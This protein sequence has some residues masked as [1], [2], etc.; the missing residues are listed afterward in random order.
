MSDP[1]TAAV[2]GVGSV[3]SGAMSAKAAK[4]A[5]QRATDAEMAGIDFQRESRDLALDYQKPARDAGYAALAALMDMSGLSRPTSTTGTSSSGGS[6]NVGEASGADVPDMG[7]FPK[8][9][10]Q[11]NDP[12]YAF[13]LQEGQTATENMLRSAGLLN[14]GK[15]LRVAT[16]YGQ[17]YASNEYDKAWGRLSALAGL[18]ANAVSSGNASIGNTGNAVQQGYSNIGGAKAAGTIGQ[19]NAWSGAINDMASGYGMYKVFG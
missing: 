3:A 10:W 17:D 6:V 7:S 11:T 1:V 9:D 18:G 19:A 16:R 12:G 4:K 14:S 2:V 13:R 5:A 15:A 8:Y